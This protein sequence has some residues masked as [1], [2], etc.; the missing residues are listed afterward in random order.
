MKNYRQLFLIINIIAINVT[1]IFGIIGISEDFKII[2]FE[3]ISKYKYV[4]ITLSGILFNYIFISFLYRNTRSNY[5]VAIIGFPKSGKTTILMTLFD[6][7]WSQRIDKFQARLLSGSGTIERVAE[8]INRIRKFQQIPPTEDQDVYAY[9]TIIT[10]G[11]GFF[12]RQFRVEFGDFPGEQSVEFAKKYNNW[13][14]RTPY[15]QWVK[16]ANAFIFVIDLSRYL[17]ELSIN[18]QEYLQDTTT[19][20]QA[21][22][23]HLLNANPDLKRFTKSYPILLIFNKS[24]L[25]LNYL[26]INKIHS[27]LIPK[28]NLINYTYEEI[29]KSGLEFIPKSTSP[30]SI[31]LDIA[32]QLNDILYDEINLPTEKIPKFILEEKILNHNIDE[33]KR[34][35]SDDFKDIINFFESQSKN[36]RH[37]FL[38]SFEYDEKVKRNNFETILTS[39]IETPATNIV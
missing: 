8:G 19:S 33:F 35:I 12:Q 23:Q 13:F 29:L 28:M 7:I 32:K 10:K 11:R 17:S 38:S 20:F 39:V 6:Q 4:L 21:A 15:F 37:I 26:I 36:Y 18:A 31:Y 1:L 16:E 14:H 2:G 22:W 5:A 3:F 25:I 30:K 9:R 27:E 24:D 34:K